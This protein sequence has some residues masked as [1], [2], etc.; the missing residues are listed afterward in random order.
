MCVELVSCSVC[1]IVKSKFAGLSVPVR[2]RHWMFNGVITIIALQPRIHHVWVNKCFGVGFVSWVINVKLCTSW[3]ARQISEDDSDC[4][5][6]SNQI[7]SVPCRK[8]C[9]GFGCLLTFQPSGQMLFFEFQHLFPFFHCY[10]G[11]ATGENSASFCFGDS[12]WPS[13]LEENEGQIQPFKGAI[14][15]YYRIIVSLLV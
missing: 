9:D 13:L 5:V 3:H 4:K 11:I 10:L 12:N 8:D 1:W 7:K 15:V 14:S 6:K 2:T